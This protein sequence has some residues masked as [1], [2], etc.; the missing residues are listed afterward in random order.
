LFALVVVLSLF[1]FGCTTSS[2]ADPET[3]RVAEELDRR[4]EAMRIAVQV[5][6]GS[7]ICQGG[8]YRGEEFFKDNCL[9]AIEESYRFIIETIMQEDQ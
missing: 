3:L 5:L 6:E 1:T 8:F 4:M 7:E 9:A 2:Q